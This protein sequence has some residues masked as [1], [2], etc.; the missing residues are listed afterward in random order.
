M[1]LSNENVIHKKE[2]NIEYLQFR[3]LLKYNKIAHA[4]SLGLNVDYRTS[5][6]TKE[7][8]KKVELKD[9]KNLSKTIGCKYKDI[10]KPNQMHTNEVKIVNGKMLNDYPDINLREYDNTDGLITNIENKV[11]ATTSADC[12]LFLLYDPK[13]NVIANVHSGWKGTVG[14]ILIKAISVMVEKYNSNPED[15]ICCICPSIRKCHFEVEKDVKD[16][17]E[18]EFQDIGKMDRII[19]V[20]VP[21][22][23]W[24]IDTVLLN[25]I[26]LLKV[27]LKEENIIDSKI[28]TVCNSKYMHSYRVEG[29][30]FKL[31][32]ALISLK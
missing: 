23:K 3:R 29:K 10:I 20:K 22:K 7:D 13:K 19:E 6:Y 21:D 11:L 28:C 15:I 12:I 16:I 30:S 27:G 14:R 8:I 9:Y 31:N 18:N 2:N 4:F 32:T 1:D 25:K 26:L 5:N 17:F 24:N